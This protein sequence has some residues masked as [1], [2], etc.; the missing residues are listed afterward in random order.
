MTTVV[1]TMACP[2]QAV[3]GVLADGWSYATWVVG[4]SRIR[5]VDVAWPAPG[6]KIAHSFGVWPATIDDVTIVRAWDPAH[7]IVLQARGWPMGE[8]AISLEVEE[9]GGGCLVRMVEDAVRGPGTL[10]PK[11]V[12]AALLTPRNVESL[13]RLENLA[14]GRA[15][16]V[17]AA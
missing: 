17:P 10:V 6:S 1:R 7:G 15:G 3:L 5:S 14:R 4:T 9:R 2:A 12:L 13:Q 8:A 11:P 16:S